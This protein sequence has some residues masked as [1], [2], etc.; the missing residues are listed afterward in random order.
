MLVF[1]NFLSAY[2]KNSPYI[3]TNITINSKSCFL[4]V[5]PKLVNSKIPF[6]W[7]MTSKICFDTSF[8][9]INEPNSNALYAFRNG[10]IKYGNSLIMSLKRSLFSF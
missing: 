4:Q 5:H 10:S 3:W 2:V 8:L 1:R 7:V 6:F 9:V